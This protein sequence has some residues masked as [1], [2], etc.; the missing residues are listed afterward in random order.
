MNQMTPAAAEAIQQ[1]CERA[2]QIGVNGLDFQH[3]SICER[4]CWLHLRR[5][6][7]NNW[8]ALVRLGET[9]HL[10]SHARDTSA[11]GL[12]GLRPDRVDWASRVVIE[13]KNSRS[14]VEAALAQA[15]FYAALLSRASGE[16]WRVRLNVGP[17]RRN[18]MHEL[19]AERLDLLMLLLD[20]IWRLKE[21]PT[22]PD[23][24]LLP[25]CAGCSNSPLCWSGR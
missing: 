13:Q 17:S 22:I 18:T 7:L 5:A 25:A 19:N 1:F 9:R 11:S 10:G 12:D 2:E 3:V 23:A 24:T 6:S 8:S 4:R 20:S 21:R 15:F 16:N 14:H